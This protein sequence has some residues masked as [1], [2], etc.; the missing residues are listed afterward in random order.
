MAP[1]DHHRASLEAHSFPDPGDAGS[2]FLVLHC[3]ETMSVGFERLSVDAL[4]PGAGPLMGP[5]EAS[6]DDVRQFTG[7]VSKR[8]TCPWTG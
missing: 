4:V 1:D 7:D 3:V 5:D 8:L 6:R 2:Q